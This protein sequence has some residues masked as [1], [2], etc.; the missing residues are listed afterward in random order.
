MPKGEVMTISMTD[1]GWM[2]G[3][4][5]LKGRIHF[6]AN[7]QRVTTQTTLTVDSKDAAIIRQ[8]SR[9]TGTKPEFKNTK[10]LSDFIRRGCS[11][12]CPE[13]HVHVTDREW[14]AEI[15]RWTITG[16]GLVV[17]LDNLLPFLVLDKGY[18][19]AI[20]EIQKV[21]AYSGRGSGSV[22]ATLARLRDLGW[23]LP[24]VYELALQFHEKEKGNGTTEQGGGADGEAVSTVPGDDDYSGH[25]DV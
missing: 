23:D 20:E 9:L 5:D 13:A 7:Q 21:T 10:T 6:K 3:I 24:P 8:L 12:H 14:I 22:Y 17:V 19:E 1:L 18:Q 16:A 2:A 4:I 15:S 25:E 11:E